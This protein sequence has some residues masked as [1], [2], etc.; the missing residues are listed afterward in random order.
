MLHCFAY[1]YR[2]GQY[3]GGTPAHLAQWG[4]WADRVLLLPTPFY[5]TECNSQ[6]MYCQGTNHFAVLLSC[7]A[8][9]YVLTKLATSWKFKYG[10]MFCLE[11]WRLRKKVTSGVTKVGI[12]RCG[13]WWCH[14]IFPLKKLRPFLVIVLWKM[15]TYRVLATSTPHCLPMSCRKKINF[16][17][18]PP[19][20]TVSP[21]A[22][23][24]PLT[25]LRSLWR[26]IIG[27]NLR[28]N[29]PYL[30]LQMTVITF[31]E[32]KAISPDRTQSHFIVTESSVCGGMRCKRSRVRIPVTPK[33]VGQ[34]WN[35][36]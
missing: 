10:L 28:M 5:C 3:T 8:W 25:F 6:P 26:Q 19:H 17:R 32:S 30:S 35:Y 11:H 7:S 14:P 4:D 27:F 24:P 22:V 20:W 13:N 21:G 1:L 2:Y 15:M 16:I 34:W 33:S 18:V 31:T 36:L 29:S 12:T 9:I 23:S